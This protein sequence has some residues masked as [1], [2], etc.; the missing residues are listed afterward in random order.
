MSH[1]PSERLAAL[2]DEPPTAAELAH[3]SSCA[4]CARE[5]VAYRN[6]VELAAAESARIGSPLTQW[7]SLA[8]VLIADGVI[9]TG[10]GLAFRSRSV[11]RP[12]L[13]AAAAVLLVAGGVIG[14][15]YSAGVSLVPERTTAAV[16]SP[17]TNDSVPTFQSVEDA[18]AM[19]AQAQLIFQTAT[20]YLA[21]QDT[22]IRAADS[23]S[24]IRN[25]LAA[26]DRAREVMGEA[27]NSAPY[28]PV[29][30]GYYLTT[31]GQR[32]ATIRQ[33]NTVLPASMRMT[34]Y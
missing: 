20:A 4:E 14:G 17:N 23:P 8:P 21:Q 10:R 6:L 9:D 12:W 15:R 11:R 19:Q 27:L 5:R 13:Q 2:V 7:E 30:N 18:R 31:I 1:L 29:I 32:E 26:L 33:L 25:R 22:A 3:L 28:D 24:A 34:S 16:T